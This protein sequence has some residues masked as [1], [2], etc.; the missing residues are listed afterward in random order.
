MKNYVVVYK[1]NHRA[2]A[3]VKGDAVRF[4]VGQLHIV[5]EEHGTVFV[6]PLDLIHHVLLADEG[7]VS[8]KTLG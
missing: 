7:V 1:D 8:F 5:S 3:N 4:D 2:A 6:T